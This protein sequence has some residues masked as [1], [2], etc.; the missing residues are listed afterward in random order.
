MV[1]SR[2]EYARHSKRVTATARWKVLRM[3]ILERDGFRCKVCGTGG[4]LEVDH[5][6]AVRTHP[7]LSYTP[8]NLQALCPSCHTKKTRIE[9]GH[10]PPSEDRQNWQTFVAALE[11]GGKKSTP[12]TKRANEVK[13]HAHF[14]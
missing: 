7:E 2:K 5:V 4:R 11:R 1:V 10:L 9:C 3:A 14:R 8:E 13:N 6:K 12:E